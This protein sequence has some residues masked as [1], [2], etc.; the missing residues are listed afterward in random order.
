MDASG[1]PAEWP[2]EERRLELCAAWRVENGLLRKRYEDRAMQ[3][4]EGLQRAPRPTAGE[5]LR[6]R[7]ALRRGQSFGSTR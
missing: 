4:Y 6:V 7:E 3:L 2:A 5:E 1:W